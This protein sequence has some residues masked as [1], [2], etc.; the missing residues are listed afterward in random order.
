MSDPQTGWKWALLIRL[1]YIPYPQMSYALSAVRTAY[2]VCSHTHCNT[3]RIVCSNYF[4]G[5]QTDISFAHYMIT[6]AVGSM[7]GIFAYVYL[8]AGIKNLKAYLNGEEG[9]GLG[10]TMLQ[11]GAAVFSV[12]TFTALALVARRR[13]NAH[14]RQSIS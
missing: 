2:L 1:P 14:A 7:P 11:L 10:S 9:L 3:S 13:V 12:A 6:S 8:G 5:L 4:L